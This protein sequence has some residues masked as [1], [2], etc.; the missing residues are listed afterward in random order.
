[1]LNVKFN[2]VK[3]NVSKVIVKFVFCSD[4]DNLVLE[5]F[6][7]FFVVFIDLIKLECLLF[8]KLLGIIFY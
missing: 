3:E 7:V 8:L 4:V 1:M 2:F 6:D 5:D